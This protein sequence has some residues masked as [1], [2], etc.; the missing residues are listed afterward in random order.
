MRTITIPSRTFAEASAVAAAVLENEA[1]NAS[2]ASFVSK[3]DAQ[4]SV[5]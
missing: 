3:G 5:G 1:S 2:A 4:Y